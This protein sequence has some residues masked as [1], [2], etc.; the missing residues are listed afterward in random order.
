MSAA[1]QPPDRV[2]RRDFARCVGSCA[3]LAAG[4]GLVPSSVLAGPAGP[5][6]GLGGRKKSPYFTRL[7]KGAVRCDLCPHRCTIER[8]RR[9]QCGVRENVD[10]ALWSVVYGNPCA[11]NID[12]VEKKPFYHVLPGSKTLSL[13]T[14]GCNLRCKSCLNWEASQA[15]PEETFNYDLPPA[16]AVTRA[17][18]YGCRS[19]ASSYVEP[20]V[21][22]E[23]MLDIARL[24]RERPVLH[25][26]HSAGFLNRA[27]LDEISSA[28]DAACIDLKGFTEELYGD[29]VGSS[30]QP[31]L[32]TLKAL[33]ENGVHTE[34]VNLLIPGKNDDPGTVRAMCR[35]IAKELGREVPVHFYRF[36]P[37]YLLK[38]IPPTPVPTLEMARTVAIEEGLR[39]AYIA[40]IPE[41]PGKHTYCPACKKMLIER[42]GLITRVI[43]LADGHCAHCARAIPGIWSP[44]T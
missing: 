23:Y 20:V 27:P 3:L 30:L 14:A 44:R 4:A 40:N 38:S 8:G 5:R 22:I 11:V 24:C 39:Y 10:G 26:M 25:L 42:V 7:V 1:G 13:A 35:W 16:E 12:P 6:K 17:A 33:K 37:R 41:H 19:I 31:V 29:L 18:R 9:G 2:T 36:Y 34:I 43:G 21:F 15:T 28:T 32:E